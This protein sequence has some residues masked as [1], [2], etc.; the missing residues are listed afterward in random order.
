MITM[1]RDAGFVTSITTRLLVNGNAVTLSHEVDLS[2]LDLLR[3]ELALS[4]TKKGC[5]QGEGTGEIGTIGV[6]ATIANAVYHAMGRRIRSF[7]ITIDKL[8]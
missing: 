5:D 4:G 2:L 6:S 3:E 1:V 8:L 7:P